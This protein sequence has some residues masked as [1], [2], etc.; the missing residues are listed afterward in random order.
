M[1]SLK[2]GP[3]H[4]LFTYNKRSEQ[5]Y[6][7]LKGEILLYSE[8]KD[9]NKQTR[10][11]SKLKSNDI[12]NEWYFLSGS[13]VQEQAVTKDVVYCV[14]LEKKDFLEEIIKFP[15]DYQI[16]CKIKDNI[17]LY[18]RTRGLGLKCLSCDNFDH[19]QDNCPYVNFVANEKRLF[20]NFLQEDKTEQKRNKNY[21]RIDRRI[22][23]T[24]LF[25]EEARIQV[26]QYIINE[27]EINEKEDECDI[28]FIIDRILKTCRNYDYSQQESLQVNLQYTLI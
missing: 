28:L 27:G 23:N 22:L 12:C 18:K 4:V 20:F 2:F 19:R 10:L 7:I 14:Y 26:M 6:F 9:M 1:K 21:Q 25:A 24:L 17:N 5:I 16:Y 11:I 8:E 13:Q 15:K 3:D